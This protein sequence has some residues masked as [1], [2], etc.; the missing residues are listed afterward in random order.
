MLLTAL[1]ALA[2]PTRLVLL[3]V[4]EHRELSASELTEILGQ[5]Q[6][7]VSR[8]LKILAASGV[9]TRTQEGASA[10]FSV[11]RD[12]TG[13]A[14]AQSILLLIDPNLPDMTRARERLQQLRDRKR[15]EAAAY[16]ERVASTWD[17]YRDVVV[18]ESAV[19]QCCLEL[20]R[21]LRIRDFLDLGTGTGRMLSLFARHFDRGLGI[22][23]SPEMLRV[24]RSH[25][26]RAD[27]AHCR[28][29]RGD[30]YNLQMP[31]GSVDVAVA[32]HVLHFLDEPQQAI[33]EATRTLRP[34]GKL[35]LIDFAPHAYEALAAEQ[36]H[37]RLGF[38]ADEVAMWCRQAGCADVHVEHLIADTA[39]KDSPITTTIWVATRNSDAPTHRRLEAA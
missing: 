26:D 23:L 39:T 8:H 36:R 32:H 16:F 29:A 22:D 15:A 35:L 20:L 28:L 14:L 34:G 37:R 25:L 6:P 19:E 2:D 31:A 30:L 4:L 33:G 10:F 21:D 18:G 12:G 1:K 27:L 7:R 17:Q 5:S 11:A 3:A 24:A 9:I 38:D 13:A